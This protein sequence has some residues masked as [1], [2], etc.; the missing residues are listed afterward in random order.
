MSSVCKHGNYEGDDE[1]CGLC[2]GENRVALNKML[3]KARAII[4]RCGNPSGKGDKYNWPDGDFSHFIA[5]AG[6]DNYYAEPGGAICPRCV[7]ALLNLLG[8]K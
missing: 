6:T 7:E 2:A 8:G 1:A 4:E 3:R 5:A